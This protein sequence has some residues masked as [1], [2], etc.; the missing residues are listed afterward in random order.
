MGYHQALALVEVVTLVDQLTSRDQ[1]FPMD[2]VVTTYRNVIRN[3]D[4]HCPTFTR[5]WLKDEILKQLPDVSHTRPKNKRKPG[6]LYA[7]DAFEESIIDG[8]LD[9]NTDMKVLYDAARIITKKIGN[10]ESKSSETITT[11]S[12]SMVDCWPS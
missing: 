2:L 7:P 4:E 12:D 9:E 11:N 1:R 3:V 5:S 10:F 8:A 6:I